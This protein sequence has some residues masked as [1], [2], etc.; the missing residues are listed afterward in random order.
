MADAVG[1]KFETQFKRDFLRIPDISIDRLYD[2]MNV[3]KSISQVCDYIV[4][5]YPNIFYL[6]VKTHKGNTFPFANLTQYDKLIEKSGIKGVRSGVVL[7]LYEHDAIMYVPVCEIKKMKKDG[8]KSINIKMYNDD[9]CKY[10][11]IKIPSEK[12]RVY[13]ESDYSVLF[14][15]EEGD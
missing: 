4:Y 3:Y 9:N 2:T 14:N 15:L 7:W 1:K 12:K 6:E 5:H 10:K 13:F 11:I 8:L